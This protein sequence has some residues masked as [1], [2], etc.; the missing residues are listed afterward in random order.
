[1]CQLA[2]WTCLFRRYSAAVMMT[3]PDSP[4]IASSTASMQNK[5]LSYF[6]QATALFCFTSLSKNDN[7]VA[8]N[9]SFSQLYSVCFLFR[10]VTEEDVKIP[11]A[12]FFFSHSAHGVCNGIAQ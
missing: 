4:L 1:M 3:L 2:D 9:K 7:G 11:Y 10:N 5:L 12:S 6:F 8:D